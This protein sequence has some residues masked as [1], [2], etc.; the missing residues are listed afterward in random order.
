[1]TR[2]TQLLLDNQEVT[3]EEIMEVMPGPDFPTGGAICGVRG[4]REAYHTGRG[5]IILRAQT[6]VEEMEQSSRERIVVDEIPI[7]STNHA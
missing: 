6:H 4:I 3:I 2:A 5:R 7:T 1:L